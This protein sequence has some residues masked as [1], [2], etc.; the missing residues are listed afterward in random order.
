MKVADVGRRLGDRPYILTMEETRG[1][2]VHLLFLA[3]T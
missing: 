2:T 1:G 3:F